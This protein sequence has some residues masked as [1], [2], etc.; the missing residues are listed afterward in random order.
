MFGWKVSFISTI[1]GWSP[2]WQR[3]NLIYKSKPS[4]TLDDFQFNN[5]FI[6]QMQKQKPENSLSYQGILK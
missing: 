4:G 2:S 6:I 5:S 3:P 1:E